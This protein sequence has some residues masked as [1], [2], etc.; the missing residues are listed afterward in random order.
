MR[1]PVELVSAKAFSTLNRF[2]K[3]L[4]KAGFGSPLPVGPG[5][6][7]L[8]TT[9]RKSG[10]PRE[11]PLVAYRFG[12]RVRVSTVRGNSQWVRNLEQDDSPA[13]WVGGRR[14]PA[15]AVVDIGPVSRATLAV[16]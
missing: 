10:L 9:G 14:R 1:S 11:V 8:E 6:V 4:V 7:L 13:V 15:S 12:D 16:S 2:I 5:L 3:P